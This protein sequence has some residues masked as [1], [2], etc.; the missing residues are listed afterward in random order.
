[1]RKVVYNK[2]KCRS[3]GNA[4]SV[5]VKKKTVRLKKGKTFKLG[6]SFKKTGTVKQHRKLS[7]ETTKPKVAKVNKKGKIKAVGKGT[8]KVYAYA[9]NGVMKVIKV[10]VK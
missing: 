2:S 4:T 8:C 1:M 9:Q 7:Y 6:A 3:Y 10:T 5:S